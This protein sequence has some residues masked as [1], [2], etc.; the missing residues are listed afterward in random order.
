MFEVYDFSII[1]SSK[2]FLVFLESSLFELAFEYKFQKKILAAVCRL[3]SLAVRDRLWQLARSDRK[4]ANTRPEENQR[5]DEGVQQDPPGV[6]A[7]QLVSPTQHLARSAAH[8]QLVRGCPRLFRYA[9]CSNLLTLQ[10]SD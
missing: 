7:R 3:L 5:R 4:T 8:S 1:V 10:F 9:Q 6:R 2:D